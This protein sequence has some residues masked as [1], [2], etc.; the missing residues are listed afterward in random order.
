MPMFACTIYIYIH[1][2]TYMCICV[3]YTLVACEH[4]LQVHRPFVQRARYIPFRFL[5]FFFCSSSTSNIVQSSEY[6]NHMLHFI[7]N[8]IWS[9][10]A[11]RAH[12]HTLIYSETIFGA[13][14]RESWMGVKYSAAAVRTHHMYTTY[15]HEVC[16]VFHMMLY[17]Y[18]SI[19]SSKLFVPSVSLH[20]A[21]SA[22]A[23]YAYSWNHLSSAKINSMDFYC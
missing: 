2:H 1:I 23:V 11:Q 5:G 8:H 22:C 20:C 18:E 7:L 6:I 10:A 13:V 16:A 12:T 19:H 14:C 4:I 15:I 21:R 3:V 17:L 9:L